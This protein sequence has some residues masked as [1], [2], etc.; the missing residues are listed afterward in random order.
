M[1]ALTADLIRSLK[2]SS[3]GEAALAADLI[4]SSKF[5]SSGGGGAGNRLDQVF[6]FAVSGEAAPA[7]DSSRELQIMIM[8]G[9]CTCRGHVQ[10]REFLIA[11]ALH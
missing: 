5:Q 6:E 11:L 10:G 8:W 1:V 2:C 3:F 7:V 4:R 9:W